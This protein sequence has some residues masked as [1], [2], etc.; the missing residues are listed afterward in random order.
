[1]SKKRPAKQCRPLR[2][3]RK[4]TDTPAGSVLIEMG[5]TRV[6]CTASLEPSVP[7]WREGSGLGWVTAEYNMLP[8]STSPR[9]P[10]PKTGIT[11]SRGTEIQRLVGRS[12]RSAVDLKKLGEVSIVIDCDV[13]QADGGTRTAAINGGFIALM[14]AIKYG[15]KQ[16]FIQDDPILHHIGAMSVG[17][18]HGKVCVD[19]DYE[20]DSQADVD[21]NVVMTESGQYIE[22]Q[23]TGEETTF[24]PDQLNDL[25]LAA[26]RAIR[27]MVK[28]QKVSLTKKSTL[29]EK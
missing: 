29:F 12:L 17:I 1:M 28:Y 23:G 26:K 6:L 2:I 16:K 4:F 19:L 15:K 13:L 5:Q 27:Q 7:K 3:T 20:L 24:S 10:R 9:K 25:L 8:G 11:D 14:D 22:L 21:F 18:V